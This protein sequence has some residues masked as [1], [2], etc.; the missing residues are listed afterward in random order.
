M[1][2]IRGR[3]GRIAK[4][5]SG[6][7]QV[8]QLYMAVCFCFLVKRCCTVVQTEKVTL[9]KVPEKKTRSGG[10][11]ISIFLQPVAL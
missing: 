6:L 2:R 7:V 3:R 11:P 9:Y 8:D 10:T 1:S 4:G 5:M